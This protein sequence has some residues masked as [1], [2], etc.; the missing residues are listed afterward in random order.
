MLEPSSN[1]GGEGRKEWDFIY[2][3]ISQWI[4]GLFLHFGCY[5]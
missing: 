2:P 5:E 4:F 1:G 3:F